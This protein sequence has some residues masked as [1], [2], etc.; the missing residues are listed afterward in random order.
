MQNNYHEFLS[1]F[2]KEQTLLNEPMKNHTSF[3]LGGMADILL[4]PKTLEEVALAIKKSK[5]LQI[6]Y[7]IIGNGSNILVLDK[8]FRGVIIKIASN[9]KSVT[10]QG[11]TVVCGAGILLSKLS[12][13]VSENSL[14]GFE[15]ASGIPGTIGGAVCMNAGAYGGEIKDV[16]LSCQ[17]LTNEGE[18]IT[19]NKEELMLEYR[20]SIVQKN[21]YTVAEV[22][23]KLEE[24]DFNKIKEK[25]KQL[26]AMRI[27]KQPL[28]SPSA[29]STFKRPKNNFAGKLIMDSGLRGYTIGGAQVS[30]KHCGF[31]INKGNATSKDV[32]DL[33]NH[34][35]QTV[36]QKFDIK[37]ESEVKII[38][39]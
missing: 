11:D 12:K 21:N 16:I 10:I 35:Q 19:L 23:L 5:E 36:K 18:I 15:F 27:E 2:P 37:L 6:P 38:G 28:D 25:I 8:G 22:T 33:I 20:S 34:V 13:V 30:K 24:G 39:E 1:A 3:K 4:L 9:Y 31:I 14:T 26:N 17:A 32:V 29:G 7:Y